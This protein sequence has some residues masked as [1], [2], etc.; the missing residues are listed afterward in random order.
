[1]AQ[2]FK[3][4]QLVL[5]NQTVTTSGNSIYINGVLG[6]TG[7]YVLLGDSGQ[8]Y[9]KSNINNFST[10]GTVNPLNNFLSSSGALNFGTLSAGKSGNLNIQLN[11][12]SLSDPVILGIPHNSMVNLNLRYSAWVSGTNQVTIRCMNLNSGGSQVVPTGMFK[13]NIIKF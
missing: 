2:K 12:A 4:N 3:V 11:G 6:G 5:S 10:S 9:P 7:N 13:V 8:F 1:M